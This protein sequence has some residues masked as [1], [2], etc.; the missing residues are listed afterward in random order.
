MS[1]KSQK[2]LTDI[3]LAFLLILLM[4]SQSTEQR[5]HEF[6]GVF[7]LFVVFIHQI[8]N[9]WWYKLKILKNSSNLAQNFINLALIISFAISIISGL[10]MSKYAAAIFS[11]F[12]KISFARV[13]HLCATHWFFVFAGLHIGFHALNLAKK[14]KPSTFANALIVG[15][16]LISLYGFW[17]FLDTGMI[18]YMLGKVQFA[19]LDFKIPLY[20]SML[21][22]AIMLFSW[23]FIGFLVAKFIKNLKEAK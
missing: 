13:L 8:L 22:G 2:H 12:M 16:W 3:F 5:A 10:A 11:G 19:F 4:S 7:A 15:S 18:D 20:Q 17:L 14:L 1:K 21:S 23:A 6:I 9:S